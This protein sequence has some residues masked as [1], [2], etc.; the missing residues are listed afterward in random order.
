MLL[1]AL[2]LFFLQADTVLLAGQSNAVNLDPYLGVEHV[3]IAE[4]G[5]QVAAWNVEQQRMW[6]KIEPI[7]R[8]GRIKALV[9]WQGESDR[10]EP[11][12]ADQLRELM[13]R[14]RATAGNPT[15][16]I[17]VIRMLDLPEF[18]AV[19]QAQEQ[20]VADDPCAILVSSDG[21]GHQLRNEAHLTRDG[22]HE[23]A[24]RVEHALRS[25]K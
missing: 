11:T 1:A 3:T 24:R 4:S 16:P 10:N 5:L 12:Y 2:L 20:F 8:S 13:T 22:Y 21:P 15:L 17:I 9:W 14:I 18:K 6:P 23:V 7:L 25:L 19:R